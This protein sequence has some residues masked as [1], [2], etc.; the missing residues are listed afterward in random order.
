M[1]EMLPQ[2]AL[3]ASVTVGC[4]IALL[5]IIAPLTKTD[6]DNKALELL[7]KL[8]SLI[9]GMLVPQSRRLPPAK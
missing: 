9:I 4:A 5:N 8:E 1:M 3:W 6:K 7:R 2:I